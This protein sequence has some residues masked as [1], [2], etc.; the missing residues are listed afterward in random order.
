M[1]HNPSSRRSWLPP[2]QRT[3][4]AHGFSTLPSCHLFL[5]PIALRNCRQ[6]IAFQ[7]VIDAGERR[8]AE[9]PCLQGIL[10]PA[11]RSYKSGL[12][13]RGIAKPRLARAALRRACRAQTSEDAVAMRTRRARRAAIVSR[14]AARPRSGDN[15]T[16]P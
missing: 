12:D 2:A 10:P 7:S 4:E 6:A 16:I 9:I 13:T 5:H 15:P 1:R 8:I 3:E 11:L 14:A